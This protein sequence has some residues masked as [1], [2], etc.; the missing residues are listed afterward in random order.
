MASQ[1]I[2]QGYSTMMAEIDRQ[3]PP[4]SGEAPLLVVTP[5]GVGSLAHAVVS[6]YKNQGRRATIVAVEPY[7]AAC[8]KSSLENGMITPI[9]TGETSMCG[10]N[11]GTVSFTAWPY[12][13]AGIDACVTVSDEEAQQAG[14]VLRDSQINAGSCGA[15]TLAAL[16]KICKDGREQLGLKATSVVV[17]LMTEGPR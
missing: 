12:L 15:A 6:H 4:S 5:V 10:M 2:V 11:C 17:L 16:R 7:T 8:L 1:W 13:Q 3:I 14:D 9:S